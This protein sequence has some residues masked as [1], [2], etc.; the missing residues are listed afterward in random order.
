MVT[1]Q[2][3]AT[4]DCRDAQ[5]SDADRLPSPPAFVVPGSGERAPPLRLHRA[6]P[7][8]AL[9]RLRDGG[10]VS[11]SG[12]VAAAALPARISFAGTVTS[13]GG[14]FLSAPF[15]QRAGPTNIGGFDVDAVERDDTRKALGNRRHVQ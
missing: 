7:W 4:R 15:L 8:R 13:A 12:L 3:G 1:I 9:Q 14:A 5:S 10:I 2:P 11:I 6:P